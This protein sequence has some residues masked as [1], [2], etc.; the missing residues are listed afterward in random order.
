M[1]IKTTIEYTIENR[2]DLDRFCAGWFANPSAPFFLSVSPKYFT[3]YPA[4]GL[5]KKIL[6]KELRKRQNSCGGYFHLITNGYGQ[7]KTLSL[8]G[9]DPVDCYELYK[10]VQVEFPIYVKG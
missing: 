5:L 8:N 1:K 9:S 7:F 2:A 10:T 4:S 3:K 6:N